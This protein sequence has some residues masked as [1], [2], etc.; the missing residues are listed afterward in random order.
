M[1]YNCLSHLTSIR[2]SIF[3]CKVEGALHH[4]AFNYMKKN[5]HFG[6]FFRN[7]T[8]FKC[9]SLLKSHDMHFILLPFTIRVLSSSLGRWR[10][11]RLRRSMTLPVSHSI[12]LIDWD[13]NRPKT[14]ASLRSTVCW[15]D[16][17]IYWEVIN[18]IGMLT[19]LVTSH[20]YLFFFVVR[21]FKV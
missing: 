20:N 14:F 19:S 6:V 8:L 16:K 12:L 15:F 10:R 4:W 5:E 3:A 11:F 21:I 18:T 9:F 17:F 2:I 1:Q 7:Q 13:I